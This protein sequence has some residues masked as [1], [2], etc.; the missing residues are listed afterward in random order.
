MCPSEPQCPEVETRSAT[1]GPIGPGGMESPQMYDAAAAPPPPPQPDLKKAAEDKRTPFPPPDLDELNGQEISLDLQHLIEDQFRGEETMAL[2]QEILPGGRSPQQRP[3]AR[4][5]LAYMPQ[6]VHSGASYANPV[7]ANSHEQAPPIK[8]EPPEPHDFRRAVTCAQYTG[9]YN[10]QPPVGVSGPYGGGFTPLPPLGA[11]LLPPLLKHKQPPS[12]RSSGKVIDKGTDEYRRR[13][14]R[15]NIAVR[16]SREKAKVRSREV[17]EKVKTLLREKEALLKRLE[18]VT[19][20]LSLHK[21]MYVHLINLNH[22]EI[23]ELCRSMLQLGAPHSSD[24][25]L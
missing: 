18:A 17:E 24:H 12:R 10:A 16:K 6:P 19:G 15:N 7:P 22:P 3:F 5:T 20:E 9:Q 11:P 13:R 21:Q 23:T 1:A 4:T 8:E 2:F 14:E 25:T